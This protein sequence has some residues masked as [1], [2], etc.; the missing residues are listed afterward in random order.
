MLAKE[1]I[2][3][4]FPSYSEM[5]KGFDYQFQCNIS[6]MLIFNNTIHIDIW[7]R[8][9]Q[10]EVPICMTLFVILMSL[11]LHCIS[12]VYIMTKMNI[13]HISSSVRNILSLFYGSDVLLPL[14]KPLKEVATSRVD[15][16][17]SSINSFSDNSYPIHLSLL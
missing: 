7:E 8:V 2:E 3:N 10:K 14:G 13:T 9:S 12:Y 11:L 15:H 5:L 4:N 6:V 16:F 17:P 1:A